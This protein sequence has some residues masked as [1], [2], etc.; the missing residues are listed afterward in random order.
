MG[1]AFWNPLPAFQTRSAR[2]RPMV[3][4]DYPYRGWTQS[5]WRELGTC[6][7][8]TSLVK[9]GED[10]LLPSCGA[11]MVTVILPTLLPFRSMFCTATRLLP[12]PSL[13]C[14]FH[15]PETL[16]G[17]AHIP[18]GRCSPQKGLQTHPAAAQGPGA[19]I[20]PL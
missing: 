14:Q 17:S 16:L 15:F 7:S 13:P 12:V 2:A 5:P 3:D 10:C 11:R 6:L 8:C 9:C 1:S 18:A 4:G 19:L 20:Q